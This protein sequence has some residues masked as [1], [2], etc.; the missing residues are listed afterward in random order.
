VCVCVCRA[1]DRAAIKCNG[2]DVATNFDP[3]IYA[4]MEPASG[5]SCLL[6]S[7]W[8]VH[9]RC[10]E[11]EPQFSLLCVRC[12]GD[13]RRRAQPGPVAGELGREQEG[14]PRRRGRRGELGPAR[15]HGVRPGLADGRGE[16]HQSQGQFN[17]GRY[18]IQQQQREDI[19]KQKEANCFIGQQLDQNSKQVQMPPPASQAS[20]HLSFNPRHHQVGS[21]S[22]LSLSSCFPLV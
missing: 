7:L 18:D 22:S 20:H 17:F 4:E 5:S 11:R 8:S 10:T 14:Q 6:R 13:R 15:A 12:R 21:W 9:R 1:Y 16:E 19:K 3:S 2:K